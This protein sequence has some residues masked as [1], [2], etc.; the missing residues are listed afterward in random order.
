MAGLT[1]KKRRAIEALLS[2]S[3]LEEAAEEARV[4]YRTLARWRSEDPDFRAALR[5]AQDQ[6]LDS[7]VSRLSVAMPA[8]VDTLMKIVEDEEERSS[9]RVSAARTILSTGLKL[10]EIRDL[11][12]RLENLEDKVNELTGSN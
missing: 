7:A 10:V 11:T 2:S 3:T 5:Q 1:T 4:G 12:G 9:T 6:A 8:A